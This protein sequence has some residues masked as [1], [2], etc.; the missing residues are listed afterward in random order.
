M[1][2]ELLICT[3]NEGVRRVPNILLP[4]IANVR[5]LVSWQQT[6]TVSIDLPEELIRSDVRVITLEGRGLAANHNNALKNAQGDILLL[7]DDDTK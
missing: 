5:Y 3:I 1:I 6:G 7:S 4:Q 2:L